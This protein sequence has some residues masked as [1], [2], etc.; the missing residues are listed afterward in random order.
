MNYLIKIYDFHFQ[1]IKLNASRKWKNLQK[2]SYELVERSCYNYLKQKLLNLLPS[3]IT[4]DG[5]FYLKK[6]FY[7]K[8]ILFFIYLIS[9]EN[10]PKKV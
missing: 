8:F 7:S 9:T 3:L 2:K 10:Y 6:V 5:T 4:E 1:K